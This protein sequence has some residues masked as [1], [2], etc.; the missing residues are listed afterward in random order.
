MSEE[1]PKNSNWSKTKKYLYLDKFERNLIDDVYW[2]NATDQQIRS[3]W[4][5]ILFLTVISVSAFVI[6][7]IK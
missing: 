7:I 3:I 1:L 4:I 2:K 5:C 6:V